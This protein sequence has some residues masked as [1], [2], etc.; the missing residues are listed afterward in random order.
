MVIWP[1]HGCLSCTCLSDQ[2][3]V[4]WPAHAYLSEEC[5]VPQEYACNKFF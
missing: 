2:H 3:T 1:I 4:N 5:Q